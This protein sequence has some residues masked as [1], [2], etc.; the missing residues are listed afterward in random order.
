MQAPTPEQ[1]AA[2]H[3]PADGL[4]GGRRGPFPSDRAA[5]IAAAVDAAFQAIPAGPRP[6]GLPPLAPLSAALADIDAV[7]GLGRVLRY[8]GTDRLVRYYAASGFGYRLVHS[9]EGCMHLALS[10]GGT[11]Q[12]EDFQAQ[13]RTL[14]RIIR[15]TG[16][17]R[18]LELGAGQGFNLRHLAA[19]FPEVRFTGL[20]LVPGHVAQAH[21]AARHLPNAAFVLGSF[22]APPADL[23]EF[24][25]VFAVES[26]CHSQDFGRTARAVA[27]C[28]AADGVFVIFDA[29]RTGP[30]DSMAPDMATAV[31]LYE[32]VTTVSRGFR[33]EAELTGTLAGA[34]LTPIRLRDATR[35]TIPGV[36]RLHGY[37]LRY[38]RQRGIRLLTGVLPAELRRNACGALLGPYL[39]EGDRP[40][41]PATAQPGLRYVAGAFR[42]S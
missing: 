21:K 12:P 14:A 17:R 1:A 25:L 15:A 28:L 13:A 23:G 3:G 31:R 29:L 37:G 20:D 10:P 36:R 16:A 24:D 18:V 35:G 38:F 11:F 30:L 4:S 22:D 9:A 27:R 2:P 32:T 8:E 40:G 41:G 33:T 34:G 7:F 6:A 26:L 5:G 39:V 42:L 19:A